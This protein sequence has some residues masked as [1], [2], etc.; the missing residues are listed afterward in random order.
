M[1]YFGLAIRTISSTAFPN[2]AFIR[3]PMVSPSLAASSSVAKL[4]SEARGTMAK[5]L[6]MKTVVGFKPKAPA[7]IPAGTKT[8]RTLT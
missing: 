5:K 1:I 4:S 3:P 8:R 7:M 6:R 2:E